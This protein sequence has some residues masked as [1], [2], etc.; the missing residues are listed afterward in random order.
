MNTIIRISIISALTAVIMACSDGAVNT[1]DSLNTQ[2]VNLTAVRQ[3]CT[4]ALTKEQP[5]VTDS[6]G[7]DIYQYDIPSPESDNLIPDTFQTYNKRI[8]EAVERYNCY[9]TAY[10][11]WSQYELFERD[12]FNEYTGRMAHIMSNIMAFPTDTLKDEFMRKTLAQAKKELCKEIGAAAFGTSEEAPLQSYSQ[13]IDYMDATPLFDMQDNDKLQAAVTEQ[14]SW[15]EY[16]ESDYNALISSTTN[17]DSL[18]T[19]FFDAVCNA[20]SF[21]EQCAIALSSINIVPGD[22]VLPVMRTL[23]DSGKYSKYQFMLWLGW[24]SAVQYFM[25]GPSRDAQIA[26]ELY[27][28]SRKSA[29]IATLKYSQYHPKDQTAT[30]IMEL[31]CSTSNI[32]RNGNDVFGSDAATDFEIVFGM[33]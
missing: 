26:D 32:V 33:Q 3:R 11:I 10:N 1:Y 16:W 17:N 25:F 5:T 2:P 9:R 28:L 13:A 31:F 22:F 20:Q 23:L 18:L 21:Q 19:L 4:E 7:I 15:R 29:F 24:R 12:K 30:L 14:T 6:E 8:Y 27:N